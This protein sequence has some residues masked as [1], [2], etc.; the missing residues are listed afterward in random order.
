MTV[1]ELYER[2]IDNCFSAAIR[3]TDPQMKEFWNRTAM[4]LLRKLN[5]MINNGICY[6]IKPTYGR[7]Q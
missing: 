3:A 5:R 6:D 4:T 1:I 2:R 7:W